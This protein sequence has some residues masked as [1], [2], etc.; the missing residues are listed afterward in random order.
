M[1][2]LT[3]AIAKQLPELYS[4][5]EKGEDA[6]VI[7]KFFA[8]GASFRWFATEFDGDDTFFGLVQGPWGDVE[9]GYF[10]LAELES[11]KFL[12]IP[13]V[14]RDLHFTPKSAAEVRK[15]LQENQYAYRSKPRERSAGQSGTDETRGEQVKI[16]ITK[17]ITKEELWEAV[18]GCDGTGLTYWADYI[19]KTNGKDLNLFK[20]D[21]EGIYQPN[22]QAFKIHD[23]QESRWHQVNLKDLA[24]G[25]KLAKEA[26]QT[27]C[28]GHQLD[29]E[30]A[31]ACF[32]DM[33]IQYA[34]F[35]KLVYG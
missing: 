15:S 7:V 34:I 9:W 14:E 26:E 32:G 4:Q 5:E 24:R 18:W 12:G 16:T 11:I 29:I 25:F 6:T 23:Y 22:P 8:L 2:L 19:R 35:G 30:D 17:E 21:S 33:V 10:S 27:H 28:G 13:G 31:D 3:K 1:K 20:K